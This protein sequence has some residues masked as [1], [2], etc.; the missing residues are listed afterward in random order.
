VLLLHGLGASARY[1]DRLAETARGFH[2]VVPD[3][4]GFGRSPKPPTSAYSVEDHLDTLVPLLDGRT[5]VVGHSTG[6]ILAAALAAR[7]RQAVA[8]LVLVGLPAFPDE[9]TARAEV[10]RLG[11]LARLTVGGRGAARLLCQAMCRVRPLAVAVAPLVI[12]DLPP[13]IVA[14]AARHT[15][16]S[17]SGTLTNVV[18]AHRTLPDLLQ[19]RRPTVVVQGRRDPVARPAHT[20]ALVTS[21]REGGVPVE[22]RLVDGDHHVAVREP[23]LVAGMIAELTARDTEAEE[24]PEPP[25]A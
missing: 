9:A 4:L 18:V 23:G 21:A 14:D 5:V 22:L 10:G 19:A 2:L 7:V 16:A 24:H 8:A 6:A 3:L 13:A 11:L 12:R 17:Y 20:Q 25:G 1:W 15:W